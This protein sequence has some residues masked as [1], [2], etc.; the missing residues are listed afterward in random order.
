M[1]LYEGFCSLCD[2]CNNNDLDG[3]VVRKVLL[4][5]DSNDGQ[6][7][8]EIGQRLGLGAEAHIAI[9]D[10]AT[11]FPYFIKNTDENSGEYLNVSLEMRNDR[12]R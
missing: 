8:S 5:D 9:R 2:A 4:C 10:Y 6:Q 12:Q 7:C 1:R 11:D 3:H